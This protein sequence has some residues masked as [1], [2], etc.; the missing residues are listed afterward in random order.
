[1]L[2]GSIEERCDLFIVEV[3]LQLVDLQ[4]VAVALSHE[5]AVENGGV[6]KH[7]VSKV[8]V[9]FGGSVDSV[10]VDRACIETHP[11]MVLPFKPTQ[12]W[13]SPLRRSSLST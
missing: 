1:M 3:T 4:A 8:A 10:V 13:S 12:A 5:V 6:G 11:G 9:V 7:V 2:V